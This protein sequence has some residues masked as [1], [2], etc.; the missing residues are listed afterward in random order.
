MITVLLGI[1]TGK[2]CIYPKTAAINLSTAPFYYPAL[3]DYPQNMCCLTSSFI[4]K[5]PK[6]MQEA[7]KYGLNTA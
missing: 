1:K 6:Y 3:R 5:L 2:C 7:L 4:Q